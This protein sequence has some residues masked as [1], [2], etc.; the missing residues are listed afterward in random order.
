M[1]DKSIH[2]LIADLFTAK[3]IKTFP[4]GGNHQGINA[5]LYFGKTR[6]A[7]MADDGWGGEVDIN[8]VDDKAKKMLDDK[9][10]ELDLKAVLF[11]NEYNFFD[12]IEEMHDQCVIEEIF[13]YAIAKADELKLQKK[14][15]KMCQSGFLWLVGDDC[16]SRSFKHPLE[17]IVASSE[18]NKQVV[19]D[20]YQQVLAEMREEKE[21]V[22][23]NTNEQLTQLGLI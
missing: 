20:T 17:T 4:T 6:V 8:Y 2:P 11:A 13:S 7:A 10:N 1:I 18:E 22:L 3:N 5:T 19:V 16:Y 21:A 23:L 9:I 12:S 14:H 15:Q